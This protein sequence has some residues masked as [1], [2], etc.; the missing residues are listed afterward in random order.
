MMTS[1]F[2]KEYWEQR[3]AQQQTGWD[4]GTVTTPIKEYADSLANKK[5][6]ILVPGAGNGHEFEYLIENGF[7]NS[8]VLDIAEAPLN[9]IRTRLPRVAEGN[10]LQGDFF[11]HEGQYDLILEQTF[12]CALHPSLREAYVAKMH[13]LLHM[14]GILA[15]L[16]FDFPFTEQGPPFGGSIAEYRELFAPYFALK[17]LE[18]A[19]NS[20]KPRA[21]KE[22]F[23]IFE[24]K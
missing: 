19:Y 21:G 11:E 14:G 23:F 7:T 3:Y 17:T 13:E 12:F 10:I 20:I 15:G 5:A 6:S 22:L 9:N 16:L 18:P 8:Y 24:K 1:T 4:A 2:D